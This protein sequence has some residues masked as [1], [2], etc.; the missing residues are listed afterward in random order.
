ML[1]CDKRQTIVNRADNTVR[2]KCIN[3]KCEA[4]G[5]AV[6]ERACELCP[7]RAF[8][9]APPCSSPVLHSVTLPTPTTPKMSDQ[10]VADLI[11]SHPADKPLPTDTQT[12]DGE[13]VPNYPKMTLQVWLYKEALLRWNAAGRPV[14]SPE[15]IERIHNTHCKRCTWYDPEKKRCKGCGCK[16]TKGAVAVLNKIKMATEH[17]P[18]ELW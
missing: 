2:L 5:H 13:P 12:P 4:F 15:E 18:R 14:R 1:D 6:D 10:E 8:K 9:K 17:C 7:V 16:V 3:K 11:K